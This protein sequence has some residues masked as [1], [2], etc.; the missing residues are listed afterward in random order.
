M[1]TRLSRGKATSNVFGILRR[2]MF[3]QTGSTPNPHSL[4]F[5]PGQAVLESA[6]SSSIDFIKGS[7]ELRRSGLAREL[8]QIDGVTRV[9]FSPTFISITK[10]EDAEWEVLKGQV[11]G[12][13]MDY[14]ASEKPIVTDEETITDTTILEDDDEVVAMIKELLESRIRPAVQEDGGDI[15]F[16]GFDPET[17]I[18]KLQLGGAC[19]GCPSSIVTLRNGVENMLMHYIP[20]VQGIEEV[21][22]EPLKELNE[23]EFKTLEDKLRSAGIPTE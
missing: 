15:F 14:Y 11:F 5:I 20:E 12:T 22:D 7:K 18:V 8:F 9:F 13:I 21:V 2:S 19:A 17:G 6:S 16:C 10:E 4:K 1:L 3:I 23:S